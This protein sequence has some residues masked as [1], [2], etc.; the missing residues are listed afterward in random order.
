MLADVLAKDD[1][2][3]SDILS[4]TGRRNLVSALYDF[5]LLSTFAAASN[6]SGRAGSSLVLRG[7]LAV[8]SERCVSSEMPWSTGQHC[9]SR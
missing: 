5:A 7:L 8:V 2:M 1:R 6:S 4:R 3:M 9:V